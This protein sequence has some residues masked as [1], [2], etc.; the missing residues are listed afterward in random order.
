MSIGTSGSPSTGYEIAALFA[1]IGDFLDSADPTP[2]VI[3]GVGDL[4]R[5]VINFLANRRPKLKL[6]A[7]F[8]RDPGKAGRVLCGVRCYPADRLAEVVAA[9]GVEIGIMAVPAGDAPRVAQELVDAGIRGILNFAPAFLRLPEH[10]VVERIDMT[11]A[12][13]KVA[14]LARTANPSRRR[15]K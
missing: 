15:P 5:A 3:V 9:E 10:I 13:E 12:L 7:A 4:G 2:V 14:F 8:D 1:S 11:V 6:V